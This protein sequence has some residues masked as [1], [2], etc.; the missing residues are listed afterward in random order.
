MDKIRWCMQAKNGIE[1]TEPN[2]NL[3]EAYIKKAEESLETMRLA[4]SRDWKISTAYYAL[5]F[6]LYA[7]LMKIGVKCEIHSCTLEFMKRFLSEY[8]SSQ[9]R[10]LME[11]SL[12]AR[13]DA[14]YYINR[15]VPDEV[16]DNMI[17]RTPEF[18]VKCKSVLLNINEKKISEIRDE[19]Q[20]I[21]KAR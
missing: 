17:K 1:L 7:I 2:S 19:I 3:A 8:F 12:K 9:E 15:N 21:A 20:K 14:Q 13:I 18:L 10:R 6:S 11:D 16:Y 4:K 5:Y